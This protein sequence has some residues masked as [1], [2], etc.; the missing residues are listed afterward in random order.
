MDRKN[1]IIYTSLCCYRD[2]LTDM[3]K[4]GNEALSYSEILDMLK[5][6]LDLIEE[7]RCKV[8]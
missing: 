4:H 8:N 1:L 7:Y 3:L 6:V 5:P 2:K